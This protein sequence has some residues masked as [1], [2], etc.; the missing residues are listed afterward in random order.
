MK[1]AITELKSTTPYSQSR[2]YNV[3]KEPKELPVDYERRTWRERCHFND[4][5]ELFIPPMAFANSLK[6]AAKYLALPVPGKG[7]STY[8][9][10][11][12]SGVLV[13]DPLILP[14]KKADVLSEWVFVPSDGMRGGGRRVEKCFPLI[15][16]WTGSVSFYILDDIITEDIFRQVLIAS[17]SL[18]G[19][20]RF[21]PRNMGYYGR[22]EIVKLQFGSV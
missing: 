3:E 4:K 20:G 9:K 10:H 7:K 12:E 15:P 17:G 11:F 1:L 13:T 5:D 2:F 16:R 19:I 6:E 14:I 18:I 22:F 21:R 8:T